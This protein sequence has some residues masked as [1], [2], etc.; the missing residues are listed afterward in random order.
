MDIALTRP[1]N[2]DLA[3]DFCLI[4]EARKGDQ[5]AFALLLDRYRDAIYRTVH[6]MVHNKEDAD[7]LTIEAF[8]KAFHKLESYQPKYAFS[9]WLFRIAINNCIDHI[10]KKRLHF[11]SIDEPVDD[12]G[13]QDY[14]ANIRFRGLNPEEKVIRRQRLD[15]MRRTLEQLSHKY[16]LMIELRYFEELSYEEISNELEMPIGT[17]KAQLHRARQALYEIL[18][19]PGA[20][21]YLEVTRRSN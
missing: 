10:R 19:Q 6:K 17:V 5:R 12:E 15:L 1:I 3:D 4:Q 2:L 7:D 16:R 11:L 21:D 8:G 14:A 20:S 13:N 18:S 9:T